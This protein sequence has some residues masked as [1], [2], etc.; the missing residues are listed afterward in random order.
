[1]N[2]ICSTLLMVLRLGVK[3]CVIIFVR[4]FMLVLLSP[5][6]LTYL[7][8]VPIMILSPVILMVMGFVNGFHTIGI[9]ELV[10][11]LKGVVL[12]SFLAIIGYYIG[13]FAVKR[14]N[15]KRK[16]TISILNK[17]KMI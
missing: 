7:I 17:E 5:F 4:F 8:A 1:M 6:I 12:G 15:E 2:R 3:S 9:A 14:L 16:W 10:E 11:V 13:K